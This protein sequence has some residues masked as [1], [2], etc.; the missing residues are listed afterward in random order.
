MNSMKP[1]AEMKI[2]YLL[3][4]EM[5]HQGRFDFWIRTKLQD[6]RFHSLHMAWALL[7]SSKIFSGTVT[8]G[9]FW[10]TTKY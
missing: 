2:G 4:Q 5:R 9:A 8:T 1:R 6:D 10:P 3:I 7:N